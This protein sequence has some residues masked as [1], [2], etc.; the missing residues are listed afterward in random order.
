MAIQRHRL[1]PYGTHLALLAIPI[2]WLLIAS[3]VVITRFFINSYDPLLWRYLIPLGLTAA[4]V[5]LVLVLVD[6]VAAQRATIDIKGIKLD[7][8]RVSAATRAIALPDNI[9]RAGP[10]ISDSSPMEIVA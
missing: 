9:G 8:G 3:L 5:P 7:F 1:W 4:F 2:T 6:Y 10:A